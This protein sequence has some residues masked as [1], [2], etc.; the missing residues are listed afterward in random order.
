MRAPARHATAIALLLLALTSCAS[1]APAAPTPSPSPS[2]STASPAATTSII[3][4][5]D[6]QPAVPAKE[7]A[8]CTSARVG[9][10]QAVRIVSL[11]GTEV[12]TSLDSGSIDANGYCS[13]MF[14]ADGP[15]GDEFDVYVEGLDA[16]HVPNYAEAGF[17]SIKVAKP[18]P[19]VPSFTGAERA[20]LKAKKVKTDDER[21]STVVSD[22]RTSCEELDGAN[23]ETKL[24]LL[25][26][27]DGPGSKEAQ[28]L[29][30]K[31]EQDLADS[32]H[33]FEDGT[34]SVSDE[35]K[36]G[37]YRTFGPTADCYWERSTGNGDIIDN[38]FISNAQKGA[39]VTIRSSDGGFKS[40]GCDLWVRV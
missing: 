8:D 29:C 19:Y 20:Y 37:T 22:G 31:Y 38:A 32:K 2:L 27:G 21:A 24:M 34:Y 3:G 36:P 15:L 13:Y 9:E 1:P 6:D 5:V 4:F 28:Y 17:V 11:A 39:R 25:V 35:V 18:R 10:G 14:L 26:D 40:E 23:R 30:P 12:V 33:A 7:G 16:H